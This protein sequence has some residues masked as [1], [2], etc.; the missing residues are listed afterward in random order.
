M[1]R[2]VR[3]KCDYF[4][5]RSVFNYIWNFTS[6]WTLQREC[7]VRMVG[8]AQIRTGDIPDKW[9]KRMDSAI[10]R[11]YALENRTVLP[12]LLEIFAHLRDPC[13][14][15]GYIGKQQ[16]YVWIHEDDFADAEKEIVAWYMM[17]DEVNDNHV[18]IVKSVRSIP[19]CFLGDGTPVV[20]GL[21]LMTGSFM[22]SGTSGMS[23][24]QLKHAAKGFRKG[25]DTYLAK[26][27]KERE[28]LADE[29]QD[30]NYT[31]VMPFDSYIDK[32]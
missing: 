22:A 27:A 3:P 23:E 8:M 5:G 26:W 9:R 11:G 20:G 7:P 13:I 1:T 4:R 21:K 29:L 16:G 19:H 25:V 10:R 32:K 14:P 12:I 31:V 2:V 18:R 30:D 24:P 28:A 6:D 17:T 15:I